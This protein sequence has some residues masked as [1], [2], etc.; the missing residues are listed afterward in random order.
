MKGIT[1]PMNEMEK[2]YSVILL[3]CDHPWGMGILAVAAGVR[4]KFDTFLVVCSKKNCGR[5][6]GVAAVESGGI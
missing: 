6:R 4:G 2:W 5:I 3:L 1:H